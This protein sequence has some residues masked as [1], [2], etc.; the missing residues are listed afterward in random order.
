MGNILKLNNVTQ[1][2]IGQGD[3]IKLFNNF[4]S[5]GTNIGSA[6]VYSFNLEDAPYSSEDGST[7]WELRLFDA[8]TKTNLVLNQS[9]SNTEL[10][11]GS[12]VKGKNSGA[13][14]FAVGAG[15][16]STLIE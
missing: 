12:F 6:R 14:G 15:S 11:A 10:P 3:V 1:G 4:N 16:N 7:R 9:V 8:Q 2:I 5:A 13:S